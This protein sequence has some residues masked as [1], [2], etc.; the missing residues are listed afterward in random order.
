[1]IIAR[2]NNEGCNAHI[3]YEI[4]SGQAIWDI[5]SIL[6]SQKKQRRVRYQSQEPKDQWILRD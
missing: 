4:F 3:Y 5:K 2:I 1:M 6:P